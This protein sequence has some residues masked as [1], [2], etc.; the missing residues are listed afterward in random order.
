MS[1][2]WLVGNGLQGRKNRLR[3]SSLIIAIFGKCRGG[4]DA[5]KRRAKGGEALDPIVLDFGPEFTL[6]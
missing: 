6:A 2:A 5:A 3:V 1:P 4:N